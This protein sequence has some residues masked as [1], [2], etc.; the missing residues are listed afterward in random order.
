MKLSK[1]QQKYVHVDLS[2]RMQAPERHAF[3][4]QYKN[5]PRHRTPAPSSGIAVCWGQQGRCCIDGSVAQTR[6][7]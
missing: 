3:E 6:R 7:R 4:L 1:K 2:Y 5:L